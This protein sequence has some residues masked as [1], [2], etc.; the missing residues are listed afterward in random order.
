[1][2]KK[3]ILPDATFITNLSTLRTDY[4]IKVGIKLENASQPYAITCFFGATNVNARSQ[5]IGFIEKWVILLNPNWSNYSTTNK[6]KRRLI[7]IIWLLKI[8]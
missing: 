3:F 7:V 8:T 6:S 2:K 4:E 1:M 5:Q